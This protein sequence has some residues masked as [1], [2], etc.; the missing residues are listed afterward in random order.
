MNTVISINFSAV[1]FRDWGFLSLQLI[2]RRNS[3][4]MLSFTYV[5]ELLLL[6]SMRKFLLGLFLFLFSESILD[7]RSRFGLNSW[8]FVGD[9]GGRQFSWLARC[10]ILINKVFVALGLC[11]PKLIQISIPG[12]SFELSSSS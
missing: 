6:Q 9:S 1:S 11:W 8:Q 10:V 7:H 3:F 2:M 4:S 12:L 5:T